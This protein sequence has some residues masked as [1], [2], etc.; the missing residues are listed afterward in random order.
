MFLRIAK[1]FSDSHRIIL[2]DYADGYMAK[3][4]PK[5]VEFMEYQRKAE[6]PKD[7]IIVFQG[8]YPFRIKNR[9]R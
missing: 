3:N 8:V 2:M 4:I 7:S 6:I 5:G 1:L 9:R